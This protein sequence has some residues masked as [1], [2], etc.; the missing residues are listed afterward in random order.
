MSEPVNDY[1]AA[2]TPP[3]GTP[4]ADDRQWGMIAHLSVLAGLIL[5]FGN[6]LGPLVVWLTKKDG[7]SFVADQGREALNFQ[8]TVSALILAIVVV[9]IPLSFIG[10]GLL[11]FPLA[12]LA[13]LIGLV[14]SVIA[15]I[16]A[17]EGVAYR[18]PFAVRLIK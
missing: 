11:L 6:L 8:I 1:T 16:K 18:Y 15:G 5:P 4:S 17:N 2:P 13:G 3:D 14:L 9:A 10:I 12:G 7:S